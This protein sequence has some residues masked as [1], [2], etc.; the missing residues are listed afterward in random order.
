MI[1]LQ[2]LLLGLNAVLTPLATLQE[3]S[4]RGGRYP[5]QP[6]AWMTEVPQAAADSDSEAGAQS[7][8]LL[9]SE[10]FQFPKEKEGGNPG[11][12]VALRLYRRS[13]D[14]VWEQDVLFEDGTLFLSQHE[15][16][17]ERGTRLVWRELDLGFG[18]PQTLVADGVGGSGKITLLRHGLRSQTHRTTGRAVA[19]NAPNASGVD[20]PE[21][22]TFGL[23]EGT[24]PEYL[25]NH[26]GVRTPM[27]FLE[28]IRAD[29][30]VA[31]PRDSQVCQPVLFMP[32]SQSLERVSV[33]SMRLG[34]WGDVRNLFV[35]LPA[36]TYV[37]Q[38]SAESHRVR[39]Y[40]L[41]GDG[42]LAFRWRARST[43]AQPMAAP[44]W[45][46][47]AQTWRALSRPKVSPAHIRAIEAAAPFLDKRSHARPVW[48][49][50]DDL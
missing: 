29:W 28:E 47:M 35:G 44:V 19:A 10:H 16:R 49:R 12:L 24:T 25:E 27:A 21:S 43:W 3:E 18:V 11:A 42:L 5:G 31:Y 8:R 2:A 17:G 46:R 14:L 15:E 39:E 37:Y 34:A 7:S 26:S 1:V 33:R 41:L 22:G 45:E 4:P 40:L 9:R 6:M 32:E 30:S 36:P 20:A 48:Y 38:V 13:L 23:A 50:Q